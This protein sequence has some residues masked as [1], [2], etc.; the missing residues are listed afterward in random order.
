M[1]LDETIAKHLE[2]YHCGESRAVTSRELERTFD[3]RGPD[4]RR[5]INRL[6]G[7]GH[8]IA[9]ST[10][11]ITTLKRKKN[12]SAPSGSSKAALRKSPMRSAA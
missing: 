4:L 9:A 11:A 6:R 7:E 1:A 5:I 2:D 12:S 10:M 3:I 8:P